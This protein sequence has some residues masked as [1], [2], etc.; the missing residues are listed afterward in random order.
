MLE[1][2]KTHLLH[3]NQ[4]LQI[5]AGKPH[6]HQLRNL[7]NE[8]LSLMVIST[9]PAVVIALRLRHLHRYWSLGYETVY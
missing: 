5:T 4:G 7:H 8:N 9:P 3:P 1:D 6:Q 2:G